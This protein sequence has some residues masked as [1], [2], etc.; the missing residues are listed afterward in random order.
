MTMLR[1]GIIAGEASGDYLGADLID[2]IRQ[3]IPGL[4]VEGIG[5]ARMIAAGCH[6][7]FPMEKLSVMGLLEV[8]RHYREL[9]GIR[10]H[11]TRHFLNDPPD[12]FISIDAPDF[13]LELERRLRARGIPT[14]HYVSPQVWAWRA[15]RLRSIARAVDLMLVLFPFEQD[16][17]RRHGIAV[18]CVGHPLAG[19][20]PLQPDPEAARRRLGLP[21]DGVLIA[22]MPGSRRMELK[23]LLVP[24]L[25]AARE[26]HQLR[27]EVRFATSLLDDPAIQLLEKTRRCL[28]LQD[29]PLTVFKNQAHAVLEAADLVLLASGTITLECMLYK[30]PMVVAYRMHWLSFWLIRALIKI[31][32]VALPNI[33]AGE[34][35]VPECLQSDCRPERLVEE[36]NHWLN[37][38]AAVEQLKV[39]FAYLH[40]Q[41]QT[42]NDNPAA[43]AILQMLG[44]G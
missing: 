5:G 30:K 19:Q 12:V 14:V 15:Y 26:I 38:P 18:A 16:Y 23:R 10:N 27:P 36:M 17:Y 24:F 21:K 3:Q 9:T 33:L 31:K 1:I 22:F 37:N 8:V 39:R 11:L 25:Q 41:L 13:N 44:R 34:R 4:S 42:G 43:K 6:N 40:G 29:L 20:I 28:K 32:Y 7:L 35:L 2:G